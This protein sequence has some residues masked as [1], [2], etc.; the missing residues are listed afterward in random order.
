MLE[1]ED[2][3]KENQQDEIF[4]KIEEDLKDGKNK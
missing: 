2:N 1:I 3:F 4:K